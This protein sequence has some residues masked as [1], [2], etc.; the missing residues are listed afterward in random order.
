M[1]D[2]AQLREVQVLLY[3]HA[4]TAQPC[5]TREAS[6]KTSTRLTAG[7]RCLF[8]IYDAPLPAVDSLLYYTGLDNQKYDSLRF[9]CTSMVENTPRYTKTLL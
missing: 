1:L 8:G 7:C 9:P 3:K 5:C 4:E 6:V 2:V